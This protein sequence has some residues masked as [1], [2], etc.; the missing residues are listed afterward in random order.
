MR[1]ESLKSS[2]AALSFLLGCASSASGT[3][4]DAGTENNDVIQLD[5]PTDQPIVVDRPDVSEAD[6]SSLPFSLDLQPSA[7]R[8]LANRT[9]AVIANVRQ[10]ARLLLGQTVQLTTSDP[11]ITFV[12]GQVMQ[13][14]CLATVVEH[15]VVAMNRV[16]SPATSTSLVGRIAV[17]ANSCPNGYEDSGL[18][19]A[20]LQ[21]PTTEPATDRVVHIAG[22]VGGYSPVVASETV[23]SFTRTMLFPD[24]YYM[25]IVRPVLTPSAGQGFMAVVI[26]QTREGFGLPCMPFAGTANGESFDQAGCTIANNGGRAVPIEQALAINQETAAM[27]AGALVLDASST[28]LGVDVQSRG[29]GADGLNPR[30]FTHLGGGAYAM[31]IQAG[32]AGDAG[33]WSVNLRDS[34]SFPVENSF[35]RVA[36]Q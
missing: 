14:I 33:R 28:I 24:A 3:I 10:G 9:F 26:P 1:L 25:E 11:D 36:I 13:S 16:L 15:D 4:G 31:T 5:T 2:A 8:V 30:V 12:N 19:I 35:K 23:T 32:V 27:T 20:L 17:T 34:H 21:T 6:V 22:N 7:S 29:L 18:K